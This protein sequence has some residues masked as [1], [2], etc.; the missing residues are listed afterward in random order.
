MI[1]QHSEEKPCEVCL[2][3]PGPAPEAYQQC[4]NG[5]LRSIHIPLG[6][7][8]S[9]LFVKRN[10]N[11]QRSPRI[12]RRYRG[13]LKKRISN[14]KTTDAAAT[15]VANK[16]KTVFSSLERQLDNRFFCGSCNLFGFS[17]LFAS[18]SSSSSS[19]HTLFLSFLFL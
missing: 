3:R 15:A 5:H 18:S 4:H 14:K 13:S 11:K 7:S 16:W 12:D 9:Y 6:F 10:K 1:D 17:S 2:T 19:A 8:S